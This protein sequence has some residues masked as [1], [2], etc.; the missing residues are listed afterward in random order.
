MKNLPLCPFTFVSS[1]LPKDR[2]TLVISKEGDK[3]ALFAMP[4]RHRDLSKQQST[5]Q[6]GQ[7]SA[8]MLKRKREETAPSRTASN[9]END[10]SVTTVES[11]SPWK[12]LRKRLVRSSPSHS[13]SEMLP[14]NIPT[15]NVIWPLLR[16]AGFTFTNGHYCL[17]DV[18][19]PKEGFVLDTDYFANHLRLRRFLCAYG[20]KVGGFELSEDDKDRLSLWV[21]TAI[22]PRFWGLSQNDIP[23]ELRHALPRNRIHTLLM[24][25]DFQYKQ[26][27]FYFL[28]D[29]DP[30]SDP[31]RKLDGEDGLLV[32]LARF[33]LP[34]SCNFNQIDDSQ[35]CRL[36][37]TISQT[38]EAETL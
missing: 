30:N 17:P 23:G 11:S 38:G 9:S 28:P 14:R 19:P 21:C 3:Q 22:V 32:F 20:I 37:Y 33:G 12:R 2:H 29:E 8:S 1:F 7:K 31:G 36:E 13:I 35:R 10:P 15:W 16:K 27:G 4:V 26:E 24:S 5:H 34:R 18:N 25:L 6:G